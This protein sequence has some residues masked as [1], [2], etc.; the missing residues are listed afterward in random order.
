MTQTATEQ[1]QIPGEWFRRGKPLAESAGDGSICGSRYTLDGEPCQMPA[2]YG[3]SDV[4]KPDDAL[5]HRHADDTERCGVETMLGGPCLLPAGFGVEGE[6]AGPCIH[7]CEATRADRRRVQAEFLIELSKCLT[8][9]GAAEAVGIAR[10]T[11]Q[12]WMRQSKEF[13]RA[14][15]KLLNGEVADARLQRA[16]EVLF[17]RVTSDDAGQAERIFALVNMSSGQD[18]WRDVKLVQHDHRHSGGVLLV[19]GSEGGDWDEAAAEQQK[20]LREDTGG[21]QIEATVRE[22]RDVD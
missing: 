17:E 3:R 2:R 14:V 22:A 13:R 11:A 18:G 21:R 12:L 1:R 7:H 6:D 5:C 8:I 19:P 4:E 20:R 9:T 16:E 15:R 10:Y